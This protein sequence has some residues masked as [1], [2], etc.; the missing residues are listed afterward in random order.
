[1]RPE[2]REM[3]IEYIPVELLHANEY[4]PNK[5][6]DVTF[7]K[8]VENI[9]EIGFV[10]P[11]MVRPHPE[12][13]GEYEIISGHHRVEAAKIVGYTEIPCIIQ[14]DFDEDMAK[15]QL[16]RMNVLRGEL[17]P[18]KFT[19]LFNELSDK[20]GEELTKDM[21]ALVDQKAFEKLYIDVKKELPKD[22]QKKLEKTKKEI[23]DVDGLSRI[24]NN[25][26]ANYGDT[27][28]FNFLVFTYG[29]KEHYWVQMSKDV[30]DR[31][32]DLHEISVR[33]KADINIYFDEIFKLDEVKELVQ[34]WLE[35]AP[36]DDEHDDE[37][38]FT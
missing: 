7:N 11:I 28:D 1:M 3:Q 37:L 29:N 14:W 13:E 36:E 35:E 34:Q 26:F 30:R 6:K 24:L 17:D 33:N 32:K 5:Q 25:I 2:D 38:D 8:L 12:K 22:L 16:V 9:E 19:K 18:M 21:M 20:Y 10:E 4:N 15:F 27:L 31:V 23:K